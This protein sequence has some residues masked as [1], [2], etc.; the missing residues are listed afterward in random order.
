VRRGVTDFE[1]LDQLSEDEAYE[2]LFHVGAAHAGRR[3][4]IAGQSDCG[5][6]IRL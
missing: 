2:F 3:D 6:L 4:R 1:N 5:V